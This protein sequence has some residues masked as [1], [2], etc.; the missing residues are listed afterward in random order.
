MQEG[1]REELVISNDAGVLLLET[2]QHIRGSID[3]HRGPWGSRWGKRAAQIT[4]LQ[5]TPAMTSVDWVRDTFKWPGHHIELAI[6][7]E[8]SVIS[9]L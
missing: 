9:I 8:H 2:T 3:V 6:K 7:Y 4:R 1:F 5:G